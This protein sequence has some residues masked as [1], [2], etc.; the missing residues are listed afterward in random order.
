M[1]IFISTPIEKNYR[2]VFA[3]FNEKLFKALKPP[4]VKLEVER[5][6]GCKKGDEIHLKITP[7]NLK[8]ERWISHITEYHEDNEQIYFIDIGVVI[9]FPLKYW[10]H[11]HRIERVSENKCMVVDDIEFTSGNAVLDRLLY[12][13]FFTMFKM[14]SPVYKRELS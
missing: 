9:P 10:K 8:T 7:L 3:L 14:R 12:P 13:I 4:M 6:D 1:K 2:D 11:I 5:F